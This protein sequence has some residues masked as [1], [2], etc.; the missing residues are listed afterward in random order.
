MRLERCTQLPGRAARAFVAIVMT[1]Q[2][3]PTAFAQ[4]PAP[5]PAIHWAACEAPAP[6]GFD[7]ATVPVPLDYARPDGGTVTLAVIRHQ[8]AEPGNRIGTLFFNPG[9]SG[10]QGTV[11]VPNWFA[12]FPAPI[13]ARFDIVSWDPRGI[14]NSTAV[15]C[16]ANRAEEAHFFA[17]IPSDTFPVGFT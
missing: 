13:R 15:Q 16:F 14:G 8:A 9:G 11:D 1:T 4:V 7:C 6:A 3:I 10:G 17:G 5:V 12:L 2:I